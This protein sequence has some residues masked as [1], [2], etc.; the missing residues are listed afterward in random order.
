MRSPLTSRPGGPRWT[1]TILWSLGL[2]V[3]IVWSVVML[4][5]LFWT[6][7]G[8]LKD[9][10]ALYDNPLGFPRIMH[11]TNYVRAWTEASIGTY[12]LNSII[13]TASS[14]TAGVFLSLLAAYVIARFPSPFTRTAFWILTA[15]M[16][17]PIILTLVPK[18][19]LLRSFGLLN[20]R[21][22]LILIYI[23]A[24]IPFGVFLMESFYR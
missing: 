17:L 2:L 18:F 6:L 13:V 20:T 3:L 16:M 19:L 22:G 24:G 15:S 8:S 4:Y 21:V 9:N 1:G 12:Y 7:F 23:A 14:V 11:F 5:P 10:R